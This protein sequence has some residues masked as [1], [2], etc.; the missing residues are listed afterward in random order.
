MLQHL[1]NFLKIIIFDFKGWVDFSPGFGGH[2][3]RT[4]ILTEPKFK[5]IRVF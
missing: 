5:T 4:N 3:G 1:L 2:V